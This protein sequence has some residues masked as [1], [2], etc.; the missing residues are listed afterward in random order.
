MKVLRT[1]VVPLAL[2]AW[3]PSA[4]ALAAEQRQFVAHLVGDE[5]TPPVVTDA[6]GQATFK[7]SKDGQSITYRLIVANIENVVAAHI[8][9]GAEGVPGPVVVG[10]YSAPPAGGRIQGVIAEGTIAATTSLLALLRSGDSYVNV[11][12]NDGV[13]PTN[14]GAGDMA[15]GEIRGQIEP[16][17]ANS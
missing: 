6:T 17:G 7:L 11:H 3:M 13:P 10:L 16:R 14:T 1:L 8:H 15:S 5:E 9:S 12:T 2:L 4:T